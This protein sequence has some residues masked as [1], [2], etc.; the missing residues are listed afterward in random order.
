MITENTQAPD[1]SLGDQDGKTQTLMMY[2]GKWVL[3]YFYPKDNTPGCTREACAFRD[4]ATAY[5]TGNI[6]VLGVS[7]DSASS[8]QN[9]ISKYKIPFT[10]LSDPQKEVIKKY[11]TENKLGGTKRISYLIDGKGMIRKIYLNVKPELHAGEILED[12]KQ[13]VGSK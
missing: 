6:V 3:L 9:F 11:D 8:H 12:V 4:N 5:N 2:R 10:L 1:F 7:K 13:L